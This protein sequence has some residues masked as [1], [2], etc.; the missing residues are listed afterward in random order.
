MSALTDARVN[1][2]VARGNK[3]GKGA[4]DGKPWH[5]PFMMQEAHGGFATLHTYPGTFHGEI[6]KVST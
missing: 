5:R 6:M 4:P 1:K 3:Y 2:L